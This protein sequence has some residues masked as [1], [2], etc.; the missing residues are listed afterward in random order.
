TFREPPARFEAGTPNVA[1]AVGLAA[2]LD[3]LNRI[4]KTAMEA[5]EQDLLIMATEGLLAIPGVR[6]Q[7]E[8]FPKVPLISFTLDGVHPHDMATV[9]DSEGIAIR[10]GHHCAQPLM[11]RL[12]L[13]A[14]AR[15]SFALYNTR[16]E[17]QRFLDTVHKIKKFF[18]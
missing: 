5:Y 9:F 4:D 13:V 12:G 8:A 6:I 16:E 14:T 7:G 2:A 3:F 10:A 11:D 15:V 18:H 17:V 1:G